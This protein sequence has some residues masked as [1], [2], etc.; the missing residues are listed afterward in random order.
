V[1]AAWRTASV[2]SFIV[3]AQSGKTLLLVDEDPRMLR[4]Y[5]RLLDADYRIVI[6]EGAREAIELLESGSTPNLAIVELDLPDGDGPML[7][8]WLAEHRPELAQRTLVVTGVD[9]EPRYAELVQS[10]SGRALQ[11]PVRGET[12][13]AAVARE[14]AEPPSRERDAAKP[15]SESVKAA[16]A[17]P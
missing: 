17:A 1:S 5:A 4:A 2:G 3:P 13:L 9:P 10:Y 11:K 14:L 12:L 6:A 16:E 7:L 8:A 15:A